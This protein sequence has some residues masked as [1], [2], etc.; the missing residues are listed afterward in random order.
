VKQN[1]LLSPA[2]QAE[3]LL[4]LASAQGGFAQQKNSKNIFSLHRIT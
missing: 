2:S 1:L 3:A 4:K